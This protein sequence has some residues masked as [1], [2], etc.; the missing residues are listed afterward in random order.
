MLTGI[1]GMS[2][3]CEIAGDGD[4]DGEGEDPNPGRNDRDDGNVRSRASTI[5]FFLL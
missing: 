4:G 3:I 5:P 1:S 2:G